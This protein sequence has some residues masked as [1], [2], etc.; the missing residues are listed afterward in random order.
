MSTTR[1]KTTIE[2]LHKGPEQ[3]SADQATKNIEGW[4]EY[5]SK[6]EH[7]GV[8]KVVTDLGKLKKLLAAKEQDGEAIQTLLKK[9][10]KDTIAVAG[11]EEKGDMKHVKELGEALSSGK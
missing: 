3:M 10:G 2:A 8:K 7:D 9:L 4:E 1:F 11:D 6:H 5:L